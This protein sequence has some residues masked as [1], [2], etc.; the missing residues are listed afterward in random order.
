[1]GGRRFMAGKRGHLPCS[2]FFS[3]R[4]P[5]PAAKRRRHLASSPDVLCLFSRPC[6]CTVPFQLCGSTLL[7]CIVPCRSEL[8]HQLVLRTGTHPL[9]LNLQEHKSQIMIKIIDTNNAVS[10]NTVT[11]ISELCTLWLY[12]FWTWTSIANWR[13]EL[14]KSSGTTPLTN[15]ENLSSYIRINNTLTCYVISKWIPRPTAMPKYYLV[16]NF[17]TKIRESITSSRGVTK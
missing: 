13:K 1:M 5:V 3:L 12:M 14:N 6:G 2:L 15:L 7:I 10:T 16:L 8:G 9:H 4:A 17:K 11:N